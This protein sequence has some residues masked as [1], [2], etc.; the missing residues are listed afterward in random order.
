MNRNSINRSRG[1]RNRSAFAAVGAVVLLLISAFAILHLPGAG[2]H[3]ISLSSPGPDV[4]GLSPGESTEFIINV[5]NNGESAQDVFLTLTGRHAGWNCELYPDRLSVQ[6]GKSALSV[7]RVSLPSASAS[8]EPFADYTISGRSG[9]NVSAVTVFTY[10][11][12]TVEVQENGTWKEAKGEVRDWQALRTQSSSLVQFGLRTENGDSGLVMGLLSNSYMEPVSISGGNSTHPV[13]DINLTL[14]NGSAVF[15][16]PEGAQLRLTLNTADAQA[17]FVSAPYLARLDT[18]PNGT[19]LRVY[20]GNGSFEG[21]TRAAEEVHP[22]ESVSSA[23]TT[24]YLSYNLIF[25][26]G[27]THHGVLPAVRQGNS[28]RGW[29][30]EWRPIN[31]NEAGFSLISGNKAIFVIPTGPCTTTIQ[32][33]E[34]GKY[35]FTGM[36]FSRTGASNFEATYYRV[37]DVTYTSI[38][39]DTIVMDEGLTFSVKEGTVRGY[40]FGIQYSA[41]RAPDTNK[42]TS[43]EI[44]NIPISNPERHRFTPIDKEA[45]SDPEKYSLKFELDH[46]G[47]GKFEKSA[48]VKHGMTWQ[49]IEEKLNEGKEEKNSIFPLVA[50]AI[51]IILVVIIVGFFTL[52]EKEK[53]EK[54]KKAAKMAEKEREEQEKAEKKQSEIE[55]EE[56]AEKEKE[57]PLAGI[58]AAET[59]KREPETAPEKETA[60]GPIE[61]EEPEE[62]KVEERQGEGEGEAPETMVGEK[63]PRMGEEPEEKEEAGKEGEE[64][65]VTEEKESREEEVTAPEEGVAEEAAEAE[66]EEEKG[67]EEGIGKEAAEE[68][69]E[70]GEEES[71]KRLPPI[72]GVMATGLEEKEKEAEMEEK[73]PAPEEQD[74]ME[75]IEELSEE[76]VFPLVAECPGCSTPMRI[77]ELGEYRCSI[78]HCLFYVDRE[79]RVKELVDEEKKTNFPLVAECPVCLTPLKISSCGRIR[80]PECGSI[81]IADI[82]GKVREEEQR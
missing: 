13:T 76:E 26:D 71:G 48:K 80:C 61:K 44:K 25:V 78:C 11:N 50:S 6:P 17:V 79:G 12:G 55:G 42:S 82:E 34:S 1:I 32:G 10:I 54:E 75:E 68:E 23:G 8:V 4:R 72:I 18:G 28:I 38:T 67:R 62:E 51:V 46:D 45:L 22:G 40:D 37:S 59:E 56:A 5:K 7:L 30:T 57:E 20:S 69:T 16:A 81:L 9:G 64:A 41:F 36:Q 3:S 19:A 53:R 66:K 47:D 2:E 63:E 49:E 14:R 21:G 58:E 35:S 27:G 73:P 70:A 33:M 39:R 43:L 15:Y 24:E 77:S 29:D 60:E 31:S 65:E 74:D 52:R